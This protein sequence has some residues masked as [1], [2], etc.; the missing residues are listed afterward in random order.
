MPSP[1]RSPPHKIKRYGKVVE[2][3]MGRLRVMEWVDNP[4]FKP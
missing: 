2:D 4:N 3:Q 1:P